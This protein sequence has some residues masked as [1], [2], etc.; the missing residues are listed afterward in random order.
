MGKFVDLTGQTFGKITVLRRDKNNNKSNKVMW[1]C[2][3]ACGK[4]SI[5][6]QHHLK[7]GSVKSCG[8]SQHPQLDLTGKRFGRWTVLKRDE[9]KTT[10][11]SYWLCQC[12]CGTTRS[13]VR[14]YLQD[15]T[16][17]S[18]GCLRAEL[19][20]SHGMYK[21]PEYTAWYS[22]IQRCTNQNNPR[23][24]SYGGRGIEVCERWQNSFIDFYDDMG[25]RPSKNHSID[26]IN[27]DGNYEPSNCRWTTRKV[28]QNNR[29]NSRKT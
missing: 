25:P 10:R 9:N 4:E 17:Q 23:Y 7:R 27:N 1:V 24:P 5:H 8:C 11:D 26:R 12:S 14:Q 16:S 29:R 19:L 20:T 15:G 22:L 6:P 2:L 18:C 21:S 28:Q 3:C 13:V